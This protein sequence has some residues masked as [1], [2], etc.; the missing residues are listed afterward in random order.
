M[1][2]G[3]RQF[4]GHKLGIGGHNGGTNDTIIVIGENFNKTIVKVGDFASRDV[5]DID[6]G[7]LIFSLFRFKN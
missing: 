1:A 4:L 5:F 2:D 3:D 6:D 7:G